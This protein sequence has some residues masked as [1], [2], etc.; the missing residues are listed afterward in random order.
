[1]AGVGFLMSLLP[2]RFSFTH[3]NNLKVYFLSCLHLAG[4]IRV[5]EFTNKRF[6]FFRDPDEL[7]IEI[8]EEWPLYSPG[9]NLILPKILCTT[10][11]CAIRAPR[12]APRVF[13]MM[14]VVPEPR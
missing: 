9:I 7:P 4:P 10:L 3:S 1:M 11:D 8:Y 13:V 6:A 2:A 12:A 5:D 14:S